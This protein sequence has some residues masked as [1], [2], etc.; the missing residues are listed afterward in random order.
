M[1]DVSTG[2][3]LGL[4]QAARFLGV[5]PSTVRNWRNAGYLPDQGRWTREELLAGQK[6]VPRARPRGKPRGPLDLNLPRPAAADAAPA[7]PVPAAP[8]SP[9]PSAPPSAPSPAAPPAGAKQESEW[10]W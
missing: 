3:G 2:E 7:A 5:S 9:P 8:A 6:R 1:T 4:T 10:W